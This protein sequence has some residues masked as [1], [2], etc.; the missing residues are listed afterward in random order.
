MAELVQVHGCDNPERRGDIVFVH[1]LNG[2]P[3]E[4]WGESACHW[5][6]WLG[7]ELPD[8]GIWSLGYENA[9]LTPRRWSLARL[10]LQRGFAMPLLDRAKNVLLRLGL[11]RLGEKPLVF[12]THSMG[13]LLVKQLLRTANDSVDPKWRAILNQTRG[14]CFVA[15]PHIG[16]D[17]A[18]WAYYFRALLGTTVSVQEL[19]PHEP[20]LRDLHQ[21]YREFVAR[22]GVN[23]KTVSFYEMKPLPAVGMVVAHGDADPGVLHS[24]IYPLDEDHSTICKP[25]SKQTELY[26]QTLHFIHDCLSPVVQKK[27]QGDEVLKVSLKG[28][29]TGNAPPPFST[30][31]PF[32]F[33]IELILTNLGPSPVFIV[34]AALTDTRGN[35]RLSFS[36]VCNE[37]EPLLPGQRRKGMLPLL[38]HQPFPRTPRHPRTQEALR[39]YNVF[40]YRLLRFVCQ[41]GSNFQ[42]ETGRGTTLTF[43]ATEVCDTAFLGWPQ[44]APPE[45][46]AELGSK[47][48][49][50]FE[51]DTR[52]AFE[53]AAG[54]VPQTLLLV[55]VLA[56]EY[57]DVTK[58]PNDPIRV[59]TPYPRRY[60]VELGLTNHSNRPL[61]VKNITATVGA[62]TYNREDGAD[63]LR[64]EPGEY[65]EYQ[66]CFP[67]DNAPAA[68]SGD[69]ALKI[70]PAVGKPVTVTGTFPVHS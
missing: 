58:T 20:L 2:N 8:V 32:H 40:Q 5:P 21:W 47:S 68:H 25:A 7:E 36:D 46:L 39:Q 13:G 35:H 16:S 38:Y 66:E 67:V 17:L 4:Y 51:A 49:A 45:I 12:I 43:S 18:K 41:K 69:F 6:T 65:K 37:T 10:V 50:D 57:Q 29:G 55:E 63:V 42:V 19:R 30:G 56:F 52:A 53:K 33:V 64:I 27:P 60:L 28:Y 3:R 14:V 11:E 31:E 1:G 62:F 15:T 26:L 23:I 24:G 61:Y 22:D 44:F 59:I 54:H 48:L 34:S 9:A 70:S